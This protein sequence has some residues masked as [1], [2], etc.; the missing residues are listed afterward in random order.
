MLAVN[1]YLNFF[2][3]INNDP[4]DIDKPINKFT[5]MDILTV[6]WYFS[7]F[8]VLVAFFAIMACSDSHCGRTRKPEVPVLTPPPTPAPSY[9]EFAPPSYESVTNGIFIISVDEKSNV[10]APS[11]IINTSQPTSNEHSDRFV[12][13]V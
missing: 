12:Q 1:R 13:I 2:F 6:V 11:D 9:R 4:F 10:Q 8:L 7:T 5:I 3:L